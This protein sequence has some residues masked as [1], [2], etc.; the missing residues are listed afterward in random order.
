MVFRDP[1]N[2]V[3]SEH[4]F[5]IEAYHQKHV[6]KLNDFV[7]QRFEVGFFL[8]F[9]ARVRLSVIFCFCCAPG[10]GCPGITGGVRC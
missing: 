1:R 5:R 10:V 2:M 4:R 3:V 9:V 7:H 8:F 6:K